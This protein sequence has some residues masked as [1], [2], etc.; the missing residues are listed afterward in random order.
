M[1]KEKKQNYSAL[2]IKIITKFAEYYFS[3]LL[4]R[5]VNRVYKIYLKGINLLILALLCFVFACLVWLGLQALFFILLSDYGISTK[6]VIL[7]LVILN[8][9]CLAFSIVC[10]RNQKKKLV[11]CKD[12]LS[13]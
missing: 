6:I 7:I 13:M 4:D 1:E 5:K 3:Y 9:V 11:D 8:L 2:I 12:T 10:L